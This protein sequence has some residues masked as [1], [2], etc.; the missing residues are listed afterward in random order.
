MNTPRLT[1][2]RRIATT[3]A[4]AHADAVDRD[5]RFPAETID[6]LREARML[7]ALVPT[8]LGGFGVDLV[9]LGAMCEA[10]GNECT[11]SA[12]VFAMHQIQV[13]SILRHGMNQPFFQGYIK[14]LVGKQRLIA[15]VTSEVGVGG[16]MRTSVCAVERAG[17]RPDS[18]M[19]L[20]KD[21]TTISYG[22][23][24]DDLLVT[25]RRAPE[26][27]SNDQSYV[28]VQKADYSLERKG[29]WDTLGMR[30]TCSPPALLKARG[31]AD[32]VITTAGAEVTSHT[33]VPVSHVVWS[34]AWL[35]LATSAVSRARQFVRTQARAK[36]G[37]VPPTALRLA[38][39]ATQLQTFRTIVHAAAREV[40]DLFN[41]TER[42]NETLSSIAFAL[43]INNLKVTASQ[44]LAQIVHQSLQI[45][46]IMGYKNDSK[47]ALGRH[48]RDS[49]SAALMVG[50]DR[51]YATNASLLLVLK[52]D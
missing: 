42:G 3:I 4:A 23:H 14:D 35:G 27:P 19:T 37:T 31:V 28:L 13:A 2:V 52:D 50:N 22:E 45:C 38:E 5:A 30:G 15:S 9:E 46:G 25:A 51:I 48:Y 26:A 20:T 1:E 43:K 7:S 47:F 39:V 6:A 34:S 40:T 8:S 11:S 41:D 33:Q 17:D 32:Q 49:L 44:M 12:M 16:E 24:A 10:L 21:A 18:P 29:K 36:P